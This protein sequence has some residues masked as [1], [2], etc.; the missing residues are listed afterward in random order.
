[1][2]YASL[3]KNLHYCDVFWDILSN[4]K[5]IDRVGV[6]KFAQTGSYIT[7]KLYKKDEE[8]ASM[9]RQGLTLSTG[10]FESLADSYT[11]VDEKNKLRS[12]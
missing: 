3:E 1:M 6:K 10:D 5:R 11:K 8:E 4:Y 9:Y 2:T 7:N 12:D